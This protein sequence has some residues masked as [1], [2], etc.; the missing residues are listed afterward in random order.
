[1]LYSKS[2]SDCRP[3]CARVQVPPSSLNYSMFGISVTSLLPLAIIFVDAVQ[4]CIRANTLWLNEQTLMPFFQGLVWRRFI[5]CHNL[6]LLKL[7]WSFLFNR[8]ALSLSSV[9]QVDECCQ[10]KGSRRTIFPCRRYAEPIPT[11]TPEARPSHA[12]TPHDQ[13]KNGIEFETVYFQK[14]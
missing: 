5:F 2:S 8:I 14:C 7:N 3:S 1:M 6:S 10:S 12:R 4:L 13:K 11:R 9:S